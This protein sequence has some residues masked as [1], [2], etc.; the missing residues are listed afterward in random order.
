M[1]IVGERVIRPFD[2]RES[3][4]ASGRRPGPLVSYLVTITFC[5]RTNNH[6][7]ISA[8]RGSLSEGGK[9]RMKKEREVKLDLRLGSV[10]YVRYDALIVFSGRTARPNSNLPSKFELRSRPPFLRFMT[11]PESRRERKKGTKR[12]SPFLSHDDI[13][14]IIMFPS[15]QENSHAPGPDNDLSA[16]FFLCS[17]N[18]V[19]VKT[20]FFPP[21][22]GI[23]SPNAWRS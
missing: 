19:R 6:C 13:T 23:E 20:S 17:R 16:L 7:G 15:C 10:N 8:R 11:P 9:M 12:I 14:L 3:S 1:K 21:G 4:Y 2:M 22:R 5:T 18:N